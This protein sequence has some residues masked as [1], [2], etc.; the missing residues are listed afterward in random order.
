[1]KKEMEI[2]ELELVKKQFEKHCAFSMGIQ[3]IRQA[4]PHYDRLWVTRE[5]ARVKE[6]YDL[7]VRY[8]APSFAGIKDLRLQLQDAAKGRT[9]CN[10]FT[11]HQ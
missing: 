4:S 5:L 1:M 6:A 2:L 8:G 11:F 10:G 3:E 9:G 7:V